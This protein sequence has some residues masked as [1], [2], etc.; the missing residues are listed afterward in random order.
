MYC[1]NFGG[2]TTTFIQNDLLELSKIHTVKHLSAQFDTVGKF[3]YHDAVAVKFS[4]NALSTKIHFILETKGWYLN[5]SNRA[6]AKGIN[7]II[8]DFQP[9]IIQCNFG[10][11]ALKLTDNLSSKNRKIPLVINFLG[12]DASLHLGRPS[13]VKKLIKLAKLPNVYATSNN[14]F[15]KKNLEAKKIFFRENKV[16]HSGVRLDFFDRKG[17]YPK[18]KAFTFLQIAS[19]SYRKG[20]EIAIRAF[21]RMM[22]KV[23]DR[24]RFKLIF[25][26]GD[27]DATCVAM[28]KLPAELGVADRIEFRDWLTPAES[29]SLMLE[30]DCFVQHSRTI[31]GQTEGIPTALAEAMALEMPVLSTWHAGIPDL[32]EDEVN[33]YL[34]AENDVDHLAK[35]MHDIQAMGFLKINRE[36]VIKEFNLNER[37]PMFGRYYEHIL[38]NNSASPL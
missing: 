12:Y 32:V 26:G 34:V 29:L 25:A 30:A 2:P 14:H 11:E 28:R 7:A 4:R 17:V 37:I 19:F 13:Y 36:K 38:E 5:F 15:L 24:T 6:F 27:D 3:K 35:R 20:Q 10:I 21:A 31:N 8:D 9:D 18:N 33:G 16:L 1:E 23:Q 22:E